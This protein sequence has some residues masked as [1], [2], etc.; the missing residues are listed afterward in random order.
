MPAFGRAVLHFCVF[1]FALY[2]RKTENA[3]TETYHAAEGKH[4][5]RVTPVSDMVC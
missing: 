5:D 3:R 4:D 1:G 2:E